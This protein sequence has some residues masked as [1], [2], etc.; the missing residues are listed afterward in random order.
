ML[1]TSQC[2]RIPFFEVRCN[3]APLLNRNT[4]QIHH[5][6]VPKFSCNSPRMAAMHRCAS[7]C[8]HLVTSCMNSWLA[9]PIVLQAVVNPYAHEAVSATKAQGG[10]VAG[11]R[12]VQ[13]A[14][15]AIVAYAAEL[16]LEDGIVKSLTTVVG[17]LLQGALGGSTWLGEMRGGLGSWE[18]VWW[19]QVHLTHLRRGGWR[20]VAAGV[21]WFEAWGR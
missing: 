19:S 9:H 6:H 5:L 20:D 4:S 11:Q 14:M 12:A 17:Q 1:C 16:V 10:W 15:F 8:V 13:M 18:E 21:A 3:V 7:K 2:T